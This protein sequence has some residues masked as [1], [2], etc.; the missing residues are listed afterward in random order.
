MLFGLGHTE[1]FPV[2]TW[3]RRALR[4]N[5]GPGFDPSV[6]GPDAG[7]AQQY[8]FYYSRWGRGGERYVCD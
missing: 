1:A 2:D 7:F 8:I 4:D 6:F 5:F 3:M